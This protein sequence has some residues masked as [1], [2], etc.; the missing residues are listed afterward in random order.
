MPRRSFRAAKDSLLQDRRQDQHGRASNKII[1]EVTDIRCSEQDE[2]ECLRKE[3][4]EKYGGPGNSTNKESCQKETENAAI[5]NRAQD[6]ARFEQIFDQTGKRSDADGDQTPCGCQRFRRDH[7]MMVA[8]VRAN[9]RPIKI[10]RRRGTKSIQSCC[11]R[12]HG[13]A[14]NHCDQ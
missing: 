6:V 11:R 3:R 2:H 7:I 9:Q 12:R 13:R 4:G 10:D 5:E 8:R 1:P 14:Q